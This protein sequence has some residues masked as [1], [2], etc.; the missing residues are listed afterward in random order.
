MKS[1]KSQFLLNKDIARRHLDRVDDPEFQFVLCQALA[2]YLYEMGLTVNP[3]NDAKRIGAQ[4]FINVLCG[5]SVPREIKKTVSPGQLI[6]P[7]FRPTPERPFP[8]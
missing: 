2:H 7:D 8:N 1:P 4:E 3:V 6:D 5:L